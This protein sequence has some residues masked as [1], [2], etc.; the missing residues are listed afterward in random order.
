[1]DYKIGSKMN[2]KN[3][4][5][6]AM[7]ILKEKCDWSKPLV[8][9]YSIRIQ[10]CANINAIYRDILL[11]IVRNSQQDNQHYEKIYKSLQKSVI[12]IN[13]KEIDADK[14][15]ERMEYLHNFIPK[16]YHDNIIHYFT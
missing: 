9:K 5:F 1:M 15:K 11:N 14:V 3:L 4:I 8:K 6:N 13:Y 12:K 2:R 16:K 10:A 7:Y